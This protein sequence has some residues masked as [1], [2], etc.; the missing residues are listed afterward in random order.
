MP[1]KKCS[2][3][4][5]TGLQVGTIGIMVNLILFTAKCIMGLIVNSMSVLADAFNNLTDCAS[6]L[7]VLAGFKICARPADERH[8]N[9][10]GR[11]E[12]ISGFLVAILTMSTAVSFGKKAVLRIASPQAPN[13]SVNLI[14]IPAAAIIMKLCLALYIY[15]VNKETKSSALKAIF[16][17]SISDCALTGITI[18]SLTASPFMEVSIDGIAGLLISVMILWSGVTSFL[19]HLD[20]LLGSSSGKLEKQITQIILSESEVFKGILSVTTF[21]YGP[22]KQYAFIYVSVNQELKQ[23]EI[24]SETRDMIEKLKSVLNLDATMYWDA[25]LDG[26]Y[27]MLLPGSGL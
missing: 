16:K 9:G 18:L 20:L 19:E 8:P 27:E 5:Q 2:S 23:L 22:N 7:A 10:H 4:E 24:Q 21:D 13:M 25:K 17:D 14:W 6:S 3:R 26:R 12:Y 1:D 11:M 15:F